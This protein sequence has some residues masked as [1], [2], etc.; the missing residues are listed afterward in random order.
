MTKLLS[1]LRFPLETSLRLNASMAPA[2]AAAA[3]AAVSLI[4]LDNKPCA[5]ACQTS[6]AR[7]A[8]PG[9]STEGRCT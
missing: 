2:A 4:A 7:N 5:L 3:A 8:G 1:I 6:A 9:G